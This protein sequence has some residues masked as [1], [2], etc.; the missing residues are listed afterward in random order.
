M[1]MDGHRKL[2]RHFILLKVDE[3]LQMQGFGV[4]RIP[5]PSPGCA[6][7]HGPAQGLQLQLYA[8]LR[9]ESMLHVDLLDAGV[10]H[11]LLYRPPPVEKWAK[12]GSLVNDS[13]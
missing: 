3:L 8:A 4:R 1:K 13:L 5:V 11:K 6:G 2:E 10:L 7:P 12:A 9:P